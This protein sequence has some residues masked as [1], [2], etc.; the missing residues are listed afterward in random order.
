M[1]LS[2]KRITKVLIRLRGCAGWSSP[3]LFANP[4][5]SNEYP[6]H[7]SLNMTKPVFRVSDKGRLK[8]V[9]TA[10]EISK[11]IG[12]SLV[13]SL[14]MQLSVL[15]SN[16]RITKALIRLCVCGGWSTPLLFAN[17]EDRVSRVEAHMFSSRN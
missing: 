8:P 12:I 2:N 1:I 5:D 14:D 17:P 7:M 4:K 6:H 3:V 10:I 13:A 15:L 16:K 9:S 11:K